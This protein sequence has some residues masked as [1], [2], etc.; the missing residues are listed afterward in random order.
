M[1]S[2][3]LFAIGGIV[4][5]VM[6]IVIIFNL[7]YVDRDARWFAIKFLI[8]WLG[9]FA[10]F[11]TTLIVNPIGNQNLWLIGIVFLFT[12]GFWAYMRFLKRLPK[13]ESVEDVD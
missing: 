4:L 12:L 5:L 10:L 11:G 9:I 3:I 1:N 8:A 2:N 13:I 7:R 6:S